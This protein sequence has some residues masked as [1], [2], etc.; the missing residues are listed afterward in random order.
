MRTFHIGGTA[1][2]RAEQTSLEA[3]TE[4]RMRF[5]NINSVVNASTGETCHIVMNRNGEIAIVDETG[6]ERERYS[7]V[8]GAKIKAGP[9]DPV[10]P[11]Q[12]LAEW[13]PYTMPIL[14]EV[15]GK[16]RF[17]DILEGVTMEEQVDE[18]T[19]LS[20]KVIIETKDAD[21][22]PRIAIKD[23]SPDGSGASIGRY[24]LPVG[25]N[26][27][28]SEDRSSTPVTLSPRSP[29]RPPR[30]RTSPVACPGWPSSLRCASPKKPPSSAKSA[31]WCRSA[32]TSRG[33]GRS[34]SPRKWGNPR[35]T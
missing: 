17:G 1:S 21:K 34:W 6:R 28:V 23:S 14:T 19:G 5:I 29:G 12:V 9:D 10:K 8:Y 31:G 16:I 11:G 13:D 26:I 22:R 7:V 25:A 30:P 18:V 24:F 32:S 2:R 27:S 35:N 20:R 33:N 15:A 3:R 4:G